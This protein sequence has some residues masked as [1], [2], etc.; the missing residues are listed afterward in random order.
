MRHSLKLA[1]V[2]VG[3]ATA[4]GCGEPFW[5]MFPDP[6]PWAMTRA[7]FEREAPPVWCDLQDSCGLLDDMNQS[8]TDCEVEFVTGISC[9]SNFANVA[10]ERCM[11]ELLLLTCPYA[12]LPISEV[13]PACLEVCGVDGSGVEPYDDDG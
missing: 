1:I 2:V 10:A 8:R 5:Q 3:L 4:S 6:F 7:A 13:A 11:D 9:P 12:G